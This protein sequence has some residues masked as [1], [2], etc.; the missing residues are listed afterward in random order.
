MVIIKFSVKGQR[1]KLNTD[2]RKV[3][4]TSD[5]I[6]Y[7]KCC[8]DFDAEWDG[9]DKRIYFK[10][11]SFNITKSSL[12]DDSG[13]CYI[14]W[15]VLAH[16][17]LIL[18]NITGIKYVDGEPVRLTAGPV[19]FFVHNH[20][21]EEQL[22]KKIDNGKATIDPLNVFCQKDEGTLEPD[23]QQD[24]T[25]TEFEQYV[26]IVKKYR[27]EMAEMI[28]DVFSGDYNDLYNKPSI[29]DV[30]L[31]GNKTFPE[32]TLV[33]LTNVEIEEMLT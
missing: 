14:P 8:F 1:I 13:C 32:L 29:E 26:A 24:L 15:E 7:F 30:T 20:G 2:L 18:C 11:A 4:V 25:P 16:T 33:G 21:S 17:G 28:I 27:D 3:K 19:E 10:N 23:Y 31:I 22:I 5:T 6:N 12:P 9:F